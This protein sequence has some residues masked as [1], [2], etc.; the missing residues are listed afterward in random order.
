MNMRVHIVS[1][2]ILSLSPFACKDVKTVDSCGDGVLDPG[3]ACDQSA[4][5]FS[6]C[7]EFGYYEQPGSLACASDC[8]LA[9]GACVGRCGDGEV[10]MEHQEQCEG[11]DLKGN[12]CVS[13]GYSGGTLTC[14][15]D[16]RFDLSACVSSCGNGIVDTGETCDDGDRDDQDGCDH[17]CQVETGFDCAGTPSVC[18]TTCGDG[19]AGGDEACDGADLRGRSCATEGGWFGSMACAPDCASV[20]GCGVVVE[21]TAGE[22]HVC[23]RLGDGE[24][25]CWG[26]NEQGQLGDGTTTSRLRP[27]R[28]SGLPDPAVGISAGGRH[29][30]AVLADGTGMC[31]GLNL[32]GQLGDGTTTSRPTP[33]PV[34]SLGANLASVSAGGAHTCAL[35]RDHSVYCWGQGLSGQVGNGQ[36]SS[37]VP[38][39][40]AVSGLGSGGAEVVA[41]DSHSCARM[42]DGTLLCW[43]SNSYHQL[44]GSGSTTARPQPVELATGSVGLFAGTHH[45]CA[46]YP[47]GDLFCWG[48]NDYGQLGLGNTDDQLQP[49]QVEGVLASAVA[50]GMTHTCVL[51]DG[52]T[53]R[54]GNDVGQL[55]DGTNENRLD[56]VAPLGMTSATLIAAGEGF[57]CAALA[58]GSVWCWGF[59][60]YGQLGDGTTDSRNEP[61]RVTPPAP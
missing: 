46:R 4:F 47:D 26:W 6:S 34:Q 32:H 3:E 28:V 39:P 19:V 42:D 53:C 30:C 14:G 9:P 55:G 48:R 22:G 11:I 7:Q 20:V 61:V 37:S 13:L 29:T 12:S 35:L 50:A 27:V 60:A 59:N 40:A 5:L 21:L 16:C 2:F 18:A 10:Q 57:T 44:T 54:G 31:W 52:L 56:P 1:L 23:A 24:V 45:T 17:L 43:G 38:W 15:T 8:T 58:E 51:A 36:F 41:G 49:G 33:A 25:W